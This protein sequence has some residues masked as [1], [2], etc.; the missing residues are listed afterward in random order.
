MAIID[1]IEKIEKKLIVNALSLKSD[2]NTILKHKA[3]FNTILRDLLEENPNKRFHHIILS[4]K[5]HFDIEDIYD[6]LDDQN[7]SILRKDYIEENELKIPK[8][9]K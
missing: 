9:R 4:M 8:R 3:F 7:K 1:W 2:K 6:L 5:D